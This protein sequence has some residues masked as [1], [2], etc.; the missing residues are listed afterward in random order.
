[1]KRKNTHKML[2]TKDI[3]HFILYL[4]GVILATFPLWYNFF[5]FIIK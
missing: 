1:M 4:C 5:N 2:S 3:F